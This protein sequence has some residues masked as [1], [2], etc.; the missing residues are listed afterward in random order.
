MKVKL[1]SFCLIKIFTLTAVVW[2]HQSL[3][4]TVTFGKSW[5]KIMC[6]DSRPE[7]PVIR[8][9]GGRTESYRHER[10]PHLKDINFNMLKDAGNHVRRENNMRNRKNHLEESYDPRYRDRYEKSA[11]KFKQ[12]DN[13]EKKSYGGKRNRKSKENYCREKADSYLKEPDDGYYRKE[14]ADFGSRGCNNRK[15]SNDNCREPKCDVE[16]YDKNSG[17]ENIDNTKCLRELEY[18]DYS[19]VKKCLSEKA[20]NIFK[21]MDAQFQMEL[22]RFIKNKNN[23]TEIEFLEFR[24][25]KERYLYYLKRNKVFLPLI[26]QTIFFLLFLI[27]AYT[28]NPSVSTAMGIICIIAG[29]ML[30]ALSYYYF[31]K[32]LSVRKIHKTY[33]KIGPKVMK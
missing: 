17:M 12:G 4:E 26:A 21:K 3:Y 16:K 5:E 23:V 22:L 8:S 29:E 10:D 15:S 6:Q 18:Y 9:L 1:A 19:K 28:T 13:Y 31:K 7:S 32:Y 11:D 25:K 20:V 14:D 24:S 27:L 33:K 30:L 2:I